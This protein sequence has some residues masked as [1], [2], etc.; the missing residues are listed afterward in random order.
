MAVGGGSGGYG[1]LS[2]AFPI[3]DS[4]ENIVEDVKNLFE[5]Q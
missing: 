5:I 1:M 3:L 4:Q 2:W